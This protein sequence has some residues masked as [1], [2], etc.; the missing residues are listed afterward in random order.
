MVKSAFIQADNSI[1]DKKEERFLETAKLYNE[2]RRKYK[3][4]KYDEELTEIFN[5]TTKLLQKFKV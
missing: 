4:S 1:Y 2:F 5:E 3:K